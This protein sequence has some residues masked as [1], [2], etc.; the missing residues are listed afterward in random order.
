MNQYEVTKTM[1]LNSIHAPQVSYVD[2]PEATHS[3]YGFEH[4]VP[5]PEDWPGYPP[6]LSAIFYIADGLECSRVRFDE[7]GA[8][9]GTLP[10]FEW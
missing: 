7:E 2:L 8:M 6:W 1:V 4:Y 3:A 5:A 10:T 9:H